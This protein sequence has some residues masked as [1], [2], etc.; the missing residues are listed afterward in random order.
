MI[1]HQIKDRINLPIEEGQQLSGVRHPAYKAMGHG[2]LLYIR[3]AKL[4]KK[5]KADTK[6]SDQ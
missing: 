1:W 2:F 5:D 4:S 3:T 6:A